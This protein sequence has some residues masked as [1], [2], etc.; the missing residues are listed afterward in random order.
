MLYMVIADLSDHIYDYGAFYDA[1]RELSSDWK[2]PMTCVWVMKTDREVT[3]KDISK[4]LLPLIHHD[5]DRLCVMNL[6]DST[7]HSGWL[8]TSFW[9]WLHKGLAESFQEKDS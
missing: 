5:V 3:A 8:A 1:V 4:K 6:D 7:D 2:H 9:R